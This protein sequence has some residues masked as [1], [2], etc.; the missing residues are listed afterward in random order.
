MSLVVDLAV[1]AEGAATDTRGNLTLV[2][3]NPHVLVADDLPTQFVPVFLV[4]VQE[5][6]ETTDILTPGRFLNAK[7]E[8]TGPDG[9]VLYI[10]Q[11]RQAIAPSPHPSLPP[12]LNVV[13]QVPFTASKIGKYQVS[14]HVEV[15]GGDNQAPAEVTATRTVRV[16]DQASLNR[17]R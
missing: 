8:V 9:E 12:R 10:S 4:A 15:L 3:A 13:G 5:D 6:S 14:A 17:R 16:S 11:I 1:L 2:G 7:I